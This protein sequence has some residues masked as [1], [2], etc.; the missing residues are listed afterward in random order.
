VEFDSSDDF[1]Q[2]VFAPQPPPG[3]CGCGDSLNTINLAV[4]ADSAF[5]TRKGLG[6]RL[7]A[8]DAWH[9]PCELQ[10][11]LLFGMSIDVVIGQR[12]GVPLHISDRRYA[13][14]IGKRA[15]LSHQQRLSRP[16]T[17]AGLYGRPSAEVAGTI[18]GDRADFLR[19]S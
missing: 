16:R 9:D 6:L 13:A 17:I 19:S 14:A 1:R 11:R 18:V 10:D 3:F 4:V 5:G 7:G 8:D 2:L 15:T 12:R